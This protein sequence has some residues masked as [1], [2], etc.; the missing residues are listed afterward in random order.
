MEYVSTLL[1]KWEDEEIVW[2]DLRPGVNT[3]HIAFPG[4]PGHLGYLG[5]VIQVLHDA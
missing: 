2:T 3:S 5:V 1:S 4:E